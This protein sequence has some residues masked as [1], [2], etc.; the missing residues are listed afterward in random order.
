MSTKT[1]PIRFL[2]KCSFNSSSGFSTVRDNKSGS[3]SC[4]G[5]NMVKK[6]YGT[7]ITNLYRLF[8]LSFVFSVKICS[9]I[10]MKT[11]KTGAR[12][13]YYFLLFLIQLLKTSNLSTYLPLPCSRSYVQNYKALYIKKNKKRKKERK[14]KIVL[15][16][17]FALLEFQLWFMIFQK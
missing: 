2:G 9:V 1:S 8:C 17:T 4:G 15:K 6:K 5:L 16:N 7:S 13:L 11:S 14:N 12:K 10:L 3:M